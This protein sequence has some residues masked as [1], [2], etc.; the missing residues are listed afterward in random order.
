[1]LIILNE[2]GPNQKK[3]L[4][5]TS[6]GFRIHIFGSQSYYLSIIMLLS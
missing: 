6:I 2:K 3:L 5:T 4:K 1:M